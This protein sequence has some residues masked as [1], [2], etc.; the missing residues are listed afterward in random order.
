[1]VVKSILDK[2]KNASRQWPKCYSHPKRE[3]STEF[4]QKLNVFK[5]FMKPIL[6]FKPKSE[7]CKAVIINMARNMIT[8]SLARRERFFQPACNSLTAVSLLSVGKCLNR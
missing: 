8:K 3:N 1:M 2:A 6:W 5:S 7:L 4:H